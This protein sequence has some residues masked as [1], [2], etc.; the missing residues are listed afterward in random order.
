MCLE[1]VLERWICVGTQEDIEESSREYLECSFLEI[2]ETRIS[3]CELYEELI[4]CGEWSSYL[5]FSSKG[6]NLISG[7][8]DIGTRDDILVPLYILERQSAHLRKEGIHFF[9]D[10][11]ACQTTEFCDTLGCS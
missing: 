3:L 11:Y 9:R 7:D 4:F 10:F 6:N 2:I 5:C 8:I 1:I